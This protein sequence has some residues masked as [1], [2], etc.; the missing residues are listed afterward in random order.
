MASYFTVNTVSEFVCLLAS[1][2]C[3]A[4]DKSKAW[5]LLIFYLL[6]NCSAEVAGIYMRINLHRYNY[7]VY[8]VLLLV[9]CGTVSFFFYYLFKVYKNILPYVITWLVVFVAMYVTEMVVN[10]MGQFVF[11]TASVMSIVFVLT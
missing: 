2:I 3:L 6:L 11:Y 9:E 1:I 10:H 4:R 7:P 8:N 5:R